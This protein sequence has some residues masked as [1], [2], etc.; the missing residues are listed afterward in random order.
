[1]YWRQTFDTPSYKREFNPPE[2]KT[3]S[4]TV[5]A[6]KELVVDRVSSRSYFAILPDDKKSKVQQEIRKLVEQGHDKVWVDEAQG[7]FEYPYKTCIVI[8]HKRVE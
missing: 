1:M 5:H 7:L 6:N 2:E 8:A 3:W 4:Y